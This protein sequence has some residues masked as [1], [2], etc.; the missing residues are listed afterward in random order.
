MSS[1]PAEQPPFSASLFCLGDMS[2]PERKIEVGQFREATSE[3]SAASAHRGCPVHSLGSILNPIPFESLCRE[4]T[5]DEIWIECN[6][7]MY[8]LRKT[9]QGKLILTK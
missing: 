7:Q 1:Q 3:P 2:D 5:G 8:R 4:E 6:Q 9:K